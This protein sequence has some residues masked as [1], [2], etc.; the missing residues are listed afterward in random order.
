VFPAA[1][2]LAAAAMLAAWA[3]GAA[4]AS[5]TFI[6]VVRRVAAL[7]TGMAAVIAGTKIICTVPEAGMM[8]VPA[9]GWTP[10]PAS[11]SGYAIE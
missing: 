4:L 9:G 1:A 3:L 6:A 11:G 8:I 2:A 10:I 5:G 7:G